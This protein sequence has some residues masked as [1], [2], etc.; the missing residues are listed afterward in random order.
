[1]TGDSHIND[2]GSRV[3]AATAKIA[4]LAKNEASIPVRSDRRRWHTLGKPTL[5][6][7]IG[8]R[9]RKS[10]T[11]KVSVSA[12]EVNPIHSEKGEQLLGEN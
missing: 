5:A 7:L 11:D 3:T 6:H 10:T 8:A 12:H 9:A 1:M 4:R 2:R